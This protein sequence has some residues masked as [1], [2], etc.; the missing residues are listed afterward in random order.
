MRISKAADLI[1]QYVSPGNHDISEVYFKIDQEKIKIIVSN[2]QKIYYK[3][4][5]YQDTTKLLRVDD[6]KPEN[7]KSCL[8][9]ITTIT[10]NLYAKPATCKLIMV[11]R[12]SYR[13]QLY[14]N[15]EHLVDKTVDDIDDLLMDKSSETTSDPSDEPSDNI[16]NEPSVD[17][18]SD[19]TDDDTDDKTTDQTTRSTI[20]K[21]INH[22]VKSFRH[23][24]Y[25]NFV[26][27]EIKRQHKINPGMSP[28]QALVNSAK[29]WQHYKSLMVQ[30]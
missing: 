17:N 12:N 5:K 22:P 23:I 16:N 26:K 25:R 27:M 19:N 11:F 4:L 2:N 15:C 24:S 29:E 7:F 28:S 6:L 20:D 18:L 14:I 1:F 21:I 10:F 9:S 30:Q 8:Q 13:I 3:Q